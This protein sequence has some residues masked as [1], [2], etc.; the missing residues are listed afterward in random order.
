MLWNL[1]V[2]RGRKLGL[3]LLLFPG[4][5]VIAAALIRV[6]MSLEAS[7]SAINLNRWG[8]RETVAGIIAV[9]IPILRPMLRKGFWT[10]GP[11]LSDNKNSQKSTFG[12]GSNSQKRTW[13]SSSPGPFKRVQS[14]VSPDSELPGESRPRTKDGVAIEMTDNLSS[15]SNRSRGSAANSQEFIIQKPV[16][17]DAGR[18]GVLIETSFGSTVE[19]RSQPSTDER[20]WGHPEEEANHISSIRAGQ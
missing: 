15:Y 8:V 20:S 5:F 1:N 18:D 9:N 11:V 10:R 16:K 19:Y 3:S 17:V 6:I 2:G 7:P 4:V 13:G 12:T 14:H